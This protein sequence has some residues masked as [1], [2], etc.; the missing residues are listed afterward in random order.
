[1]GDSL[2]VTGFPYNV[3]AI[4][5]TV[6]QR[7]TRCL[8]SSQGVRRLGSAALDLSYVAAGRF[9][10][11]WEENLQPWDVAAGYLI[12]TEAGGRVTDFDNRPFKPEM[13]SILASNGCIHNEMINLL[14]LKETE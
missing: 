12:V 10:A 9:E 2:L 5:D 8:A 4:M 3:K 13:K 11:F 7:F 14:T 6:M 1:M